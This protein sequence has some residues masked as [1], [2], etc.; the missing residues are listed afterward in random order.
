M[1]EPSTLSLFRS[2]LFLP[3]T[4]QLL[5]Y[6]IY[7]GGKSN[8]KNAPQLRGSFNMFIVVIFTKG[9]NGC[10]IRFEYGPRPRG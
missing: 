9:L 6:T 1:P 4:L 5:P 10:S 8:N 7:Q 3:Y 2:P